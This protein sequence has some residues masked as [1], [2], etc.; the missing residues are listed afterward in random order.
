MVVI[1]EKSFHIE[2][3]RTMKK[4]VSLLIWKWYSH[5]AVIFQKSEE[6]FIGSQGLDSIP[7]TLIKCLLLVGFVPDS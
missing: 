3:K 4:Y 7:R 6:A 1:L 2:S 5:R